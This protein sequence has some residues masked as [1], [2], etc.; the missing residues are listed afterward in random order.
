[1]LY[2]IDVWRMS[3]LQA[4]AAQLRIHFPNVSPISPEN[5]SLPSGREDRLQCYSAYPIATRKKKRK[6]MLPTTSFAV[7]ASCEREVDKDIPMWCKDVPVFFF[8]G[9][10]VRICPHFIVLRFTNKLIFRWWQPAKRGGKKTK[11]LSYRARTCKKSHTC[12]HIP[13]TY[14]H[15]VTHKMNTR[16]KW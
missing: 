1:M 9:W 10:L 5:L 11:T 7:T 15:K 12:T 14:V 13:N 3:S 8:G 4:Y 6:S 16:C 2:L